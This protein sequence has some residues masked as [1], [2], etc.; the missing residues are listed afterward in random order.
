[1]HVVSLKGTIL[2]GIRNEK[3]E[4]KILIF[5]TL[6]HISSLVIVV[7][8]SLLFTNEEKLVAL[9]VCSS[10]IRVATSG[11]RKIPCSVIVAVE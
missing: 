11:F 5:I 7:H 3:N 9:L 2:N 1:M 4:T 8:K 10:F 6:E